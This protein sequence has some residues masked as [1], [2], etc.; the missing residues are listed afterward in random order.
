[1]VEELRKRLS[2]SKQAV[3]KFNAQ[4]FDLRKL[5]DAELKEHPVK[6]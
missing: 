5:N 2:V 6:I 3:R 4:R 1:V